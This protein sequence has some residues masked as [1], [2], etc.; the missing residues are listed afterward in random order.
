M[1]P[2]YCF[3][4]CLLPAA[5]GPLSAAAD[6]AI[7]SETTVTFLLNGRPYEKPV[8]YTVK[9]YGQMVWPTQ[10]PK[11]I[12]RGESMVYSYSADCASYPCVINQSYNLN[13]RRID[14]CSVEGTTAGSKFTIKEIGR[15]PAT[16]CDY[17]GGGQVCQSNFELPSDL[18]SSTQGP[19]PG[20]K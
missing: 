10:P 4:F 19:A 20:N 13:Y 9:C 18:F 7:P 14:F 5:L 11:Q 8:S 17:A 12:I 2:A 3:L 1:R 15:H 6:I 16:K